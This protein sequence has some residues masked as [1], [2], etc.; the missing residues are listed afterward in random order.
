MASYNSS[1]Y[2]PITPPFNGDNQS[3]LPDSAHSRTTSGSSLYSTNSSPDSINTALTTPIKSPIRNHGPL[4]LPKIRPQDQN[5]DTPPPSKRHRKALSNT[6]NPPGTYLEKPAVPRSSTSPPDCASLTSPLSAVSASSVDSFQSSSTLSSPLA[7]HSAQNRRPGYHS[8]SASASSLDNVILGR[9][10]FPT[11]RQYPSYLPPAQYSP[12]VVP[13]SST[14]VPPSPPRRPVRQHI[15]PAELQYSISEVDTSTT[16]LLD[17]LT[18]PNPTPSLVRHISN[19]G[20]G[21]NLHFWWDIRNLRTWTDFTLETIERI[22]DFNRL[23]RTEVPANALPTPSQGTSNLQ[24]ETEAA[25][26]DLCKDY[27]A[28]KVNAA[29]K[30]AQGQPHISMR[31][32]LSRDGR[33]QPEFV[34]SYQDD[35]EGTIYGGGRGRVVGIVKSFDRWNT[36]MRTDKPHRQVEYLQGLSH[37]HRHMRENSCRYGFIITE[38]ELV[39]VRAGTEPIP[40]FGF[41]ELAKPISIE[42]RGRDQLTACLALWYLHMLAK[43]VPLLGQAGAKMNVGP[44]AALS[45]NNC[46]DKDDWIPQPQIGEK[47]EAKRLRGWVF[48]EEPYHRREGPGRPGKRWHK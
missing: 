44:P 19:L 31:V 43:E 13:G 23:L 9:F 34:S 17:Y 14:F 42:T 5:F 4:L 45:R 21:A 30:V 18:A 48:P 35:F 33:R 15:L 7:L 24:P 20:R 28:T 26:Q 16:T 29:S 37:L 6:F 1:Y 11:Y 12:S 27:Y 8:R 3:L 10:G 46:L 47:R 41:L 38:I 32:Q 40:H 36:G 25:L 39:C 22:P 2:R